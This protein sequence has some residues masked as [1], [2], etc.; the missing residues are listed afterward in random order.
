MIERLLNRLREKVSKGYL[1]LKR[2]DFVG[3]WES[4]ELLNRG[5]GKYWEHFE[6]PNLN[7]FYIPWAK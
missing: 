7:I 5:K 4:R 2:Q 3:D 6:C 1:G